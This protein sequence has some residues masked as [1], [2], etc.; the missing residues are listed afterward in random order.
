VFI[1]GEIPDIEDT[2][3]YDPPLHRLGHD[4]SGKIGVDDLGE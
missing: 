1:E 4:G 3:V 2:V